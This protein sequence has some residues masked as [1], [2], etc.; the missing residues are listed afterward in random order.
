MQRKGKWKQKRNEKEKGGKTGDH[1][2]FFIS[3]RACFFQMR[4]RHVLDISDRPKD[5]RSIGQ[6]QLKVIIN[7]NVVELETPVLHAKFQNIGLL[8]QEKNNFKG[9]Y[10]LLAW[11]PSS[12]F[13]FGWPTDFREKFVLNN[14]HITPSRGRNRLLSFISKLYNFAFSYSNAYGT[15]FDRPVK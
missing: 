9:C 10:C 7:T 8:G 14:C 4:N 11:R 2:L 5:M 13:H 6:V 1:F 12:S 15:E 3:P